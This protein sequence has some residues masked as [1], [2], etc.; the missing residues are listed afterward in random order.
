MN[1]PRSVLWYAGALVFCMNI[2]AMFTVTAA[3]LILHGEQGEVEWHHWLLALFGIPFTPL[4][5][6][7][8]WI[9]ASEEKRSRP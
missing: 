1:R 4:F 8:L 5:L 3:L 6:F 2:P 9:L 7:G